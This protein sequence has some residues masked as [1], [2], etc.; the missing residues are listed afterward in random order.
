[1][2]RQILKSAPVWETF[3]TPT[4]VICTLPTAYVSVSIETSRNSKSI[5]ILGF[6]S[7]A[8]ITTSCGVPW[9]FLNAF[10]IHKSRRNL[11]HRNNRINEK[12]PYI[13]G[14]KF[15]FSLGPAI[16]IYRAPAWCEYK[17]RI[18]SRRIFSRG[19]QIFKKSNSCLDFMSP[20]C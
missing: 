18:N 13:G 20:G 1:M 9:I 10:D 19:K 12:P 8:L 7:A 4:F 15:T 11:V 6:P 2:G 3:H 5:Q 17:N 16:H 14:G